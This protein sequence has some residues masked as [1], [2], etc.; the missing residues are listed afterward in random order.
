MDRLD[1]VAGLSRRGW[2][3]FES[4]SGRFCSGFGLTVLWY[5]RPGMDRTTKI[6]VALGIFLPLAFFLY[7]LWL[8]M[9]W[10]R[11]RHELDG[12]LVTF[13]FL[14]G[15]LCLEPFACPVRQIRQQP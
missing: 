13:E 7:M 5:P 14:S 1:L 3:F 6:I 15:A 9:R 11:R 2:S 10:G 4:E 12:Y 8:A